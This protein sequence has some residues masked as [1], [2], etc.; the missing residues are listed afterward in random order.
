MAPPPSFRLVSVCLSS[1]QRSFLLAARRHGYCSNN[2]QN[3]L[4]RGWVGSHCSLRLA[5]RGSRR[6]STGRGIEK[7][8]TCFKRW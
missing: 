1:Q 4:S 8:E 3:L 5:P 7:Q 6:S 2:H